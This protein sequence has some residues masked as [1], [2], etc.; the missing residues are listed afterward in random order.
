MKKVT[1]DEYQ[2]L[3]DPNTSTV[4]FT[5]SLRLLGASSYGPI[6][7]LLDEIV[8]QKPKIITVQLKNLQFLNSSG[9]NALSKFIIRVRNEKQSEIVV[10]GTEAYPWQSK[11]LRNLQRLMPELRLEI[12]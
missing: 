7:E 12:S 10:H 3:Y 2:I 11:S 8:D 4:E 5:G 9:I 6:I 1:G